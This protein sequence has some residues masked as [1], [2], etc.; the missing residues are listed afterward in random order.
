MY[1][2]T[3]DRILIGNEMMLL[4]AEQALDGRDG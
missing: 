4:F 3:M 1:G 2:I